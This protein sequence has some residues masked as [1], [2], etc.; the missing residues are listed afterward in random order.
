MRLDPVRWLDHLEDARARAL[1]GDAEGVH[2]VR[3][4]VRRL[5]VWL[6]F[7]RRTR[8]LDRELRWLGRALAPL[9]DLD[10][11]GEV[12]TGEAR[13]PLRADAEAK[14]T[15]ALGSDRAAKLVE[16]LGALRWPRRER[17]ERVLARF[18]EELDAQRSALTPG[19]GDQV[20]RVRR[21]LRR[22]RYAR[23]W[24]GHDARP[25]AAEQDTLGAL[26]DLLA[27]ARFARDLGTPPPPQLE[28]AIAQA[29]T[30]VGVAPP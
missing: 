17:A 14:A 19:D 29:L 5:R 12:L 2:Q 8:A 21:A 26:C 7:K 15:R 23:D 18:E 11:F 25:L 30:R 16:A 6:S 3:V 13:A 4:A 27:L 9:R 28:A 10:V 22:V 24:L 1:A 20:H